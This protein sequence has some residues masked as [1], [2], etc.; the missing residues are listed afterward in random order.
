MSVMQDQHAAIYLE[1]PPW[2]V[3]DKE[4]N[5]DIYLCAL[6]SLILRLARGLTI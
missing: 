2:E 4:K 6:H 5:S 1:F 3:V